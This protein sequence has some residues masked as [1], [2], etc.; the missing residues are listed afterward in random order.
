MMAKLLSIRW[1]IVHGRLR[2]YPSV[3]SS[4]QWNSI[5]LAIS[6]SQA[7]S[8]MKSQM[9]SSNTWEALPSIN[10]RCLPW[11][12]GF[13]VPRGEL[14]KEAVVDGAPLGSLVV[15]SELSLLTDGLS[16]SLSLLRAKPSSSHGH[17]VFRWHQ[18][19]PS[20]SACFGLVSAKD[21][22]KAG[23]KEII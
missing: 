5:F 8:Q 21:K 13:Y 7:M 14:L 15:L 12:D 16:C 11:T 22:I 3:H 2:W 17:N 20:G 1:N 6:R 10:E 19:G 18:C 4:P 23:R 9:W